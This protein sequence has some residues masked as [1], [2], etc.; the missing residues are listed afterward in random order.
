[1]I[2]LKNLETF[3]WVAQ[4][5]GFR[6]AAQR[7][8]TTQPGISQRIAALEN[9]LGVK[10]F[11]RDARRVSLTAKG[12]ELLPYAEQMLKLRADILDIAESRQAYSGNV[13]MGVSETIVHTSLIKLVEAIRSTYPMITLDIEVDVSRNLRE[14]LLKGALDIVF[15]L[16]PIQEPN[17]C[18]FDLASYPLNWIASPRLPLHGRPLSLHEVARYPVI[19]Y[20]KNTLPHM[21]IRDLFTEAKM[22]NFKIY[23]NTSLSAMVR[24]CAEGVGVGVI[25]SRV[26]GRELENH[27]LELI[28]VVGGELPEMSFTIS[29]MQTADAHLLKAITELALELNQSI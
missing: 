18:N 15:L 14:N 28:E 29:Y 13:R 16:G 21:A 27:E 26:I 25:P 1:M 19:T 22:K 8:H 6:L 2:D 4:L 11:E 17:V 10:L 12:R 7:L 9:E 20:P 5:G 23:G 3:I 24:L